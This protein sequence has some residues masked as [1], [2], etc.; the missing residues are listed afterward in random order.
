MLQPKCYDSFHSVLP[1]SLE[2]L[3]F[4]YSNAAGLRSVLVVAPLCMHAGNFSSTRDTSC[5]VFHM[6]CDF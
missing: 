4:E 1:L 5:F 3:V 2:P 6:G